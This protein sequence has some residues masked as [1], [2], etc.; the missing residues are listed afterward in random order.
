MWM[1]AVTCFK[2]FGL[3]TQWVKFDFV[4]NFAITKKNGMSRD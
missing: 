2:R 4:P 1:Q 3:F